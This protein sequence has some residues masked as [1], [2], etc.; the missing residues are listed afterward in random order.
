M[1][2]LTSFEESVREQNLAVRGLIVWRDEEVAARYQPEPEQR[3]NLYSGTKSF[4]STACAFAV[5]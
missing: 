3:Q 2:N 1:M 5:Q 4:T